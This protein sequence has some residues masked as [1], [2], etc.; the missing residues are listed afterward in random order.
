MCQAHPVIAD[1]SSIQD[2]TDDG[3]CLAHPVMSVEA[4]GWVLIGQ[5]ER[6]GVEAQRSP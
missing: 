4:H 5:Q 1:N 6:V 3:M 2:L